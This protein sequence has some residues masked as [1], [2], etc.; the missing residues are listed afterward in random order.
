MNR[1]LELQA[2]NDKIGAEMLTESGRF[3]AL[4]NRESNGLAPRAIT[5]F[6]LFQ[7]PE[8]IADRMALMIE[9][10]EILEPSAGLGRLYKAVKKVNPS[11]QFTL[12]EENKDCLSELYN[13]EDVNLK[14]GDFLQMEELD[15]FDAV[16]MNPPFKMG[17]D[18]KHIL[19]ALKFL[20]TGRKLVSLCY[21]GVKQNKILKPL[22]NSWEVLPEGSF[23]SEGTRAS[24][25][26]ITIK[27][28]LK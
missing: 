24:I 13:F 25:A 26:L 6:N 8:L 12:I 9:G 3:T 2:K 14:Q 21:N 16:V 23:R 28:G 11:A 19:H 22:C 10:A 20:K 18:I 17:R 15:L 1:L 4:A 5:S 7:T 27:K